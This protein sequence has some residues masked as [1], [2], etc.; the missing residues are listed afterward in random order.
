MEA[1]W[2]C[3]DGT[4]RDPVDCSCKPTKL[5]FDPKDWLTMISKPSKEDV[6][7]LALV[8]FR[9]IDVNS[10]DCWTYWEVYAAMEAN[11]R[12]HN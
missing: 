10:D 8:I 7:R 6:E 11:A 9:A 1:Y 3:P 2:A 12:F 4:Y 5:P